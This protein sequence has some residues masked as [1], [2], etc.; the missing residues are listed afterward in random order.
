MSPR[1]KRQIV[2][3]LALLFIIGFG[4]LT[5][6]AIAEHGVTLGSLFSIFIVILLGI[7]VI[8]ALLN[9]PDR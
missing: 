4:G 1:L 6:G 2:L 8:G 9:P 7:G 5:Y 3:G